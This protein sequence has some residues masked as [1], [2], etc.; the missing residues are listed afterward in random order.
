ASS[1]AGGAAREARGGTDGTWG[2]RVAGGLPSSPRGGPAPYRAAR[3]AAAADAAKK[4]AGGPARVVF[5]KQVAP[6]LQ[7]YCVK[8]HGGAKPRAGFALDKIKTDREA[9]ADRKTWEKVVRALQAREMPPE[10][11][12]QPA[13]AERDLLLTFL[14]QRLAAVD[15]TKQRDP[16]RV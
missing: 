8:C 4:D 10:D 15:C 7:K 3:P 6:L 12:P 1:E 16:G 2:R 11:R 13:A 5:S 14:D 9:D